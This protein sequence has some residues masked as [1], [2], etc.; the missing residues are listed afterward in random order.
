MNRRIHG[1]NSTPLVSNWMAGPN[2]PPPPP[3]LSKFWFWTYFC[4]V[5]QR[6]AEAIRPRPAAAPARSPPASVRGGRRGGAPVEREPG[7]AWFARPAAG[8]AAAGPGT[9][10]EVAT[11]R[12]RAPA[13]RVSAGF[14][15][16]RRVPARV[17][18]RIGR[19]GRP[20]RERACAI[21]SMSDSSALGGGSFGAACRAW[22]ARTRTGRSHARAAAPAAPRSRAAWPA[23][24]A[25]RAAASTG[26]RGS[27]G[28]RR[29]VPSTRKCANTEII[30]P[31][32]REMAR[33]MVGVSGRASS[34]SMYIRPLTIIP[35]AR[36]GCRGCAAR[37]PR[38][39]TLDRPM[40]PSPAT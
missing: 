27:S 10:A 30:T 13:G 6:L 35:G 16:L 5:L 3:G 28:R 17:R 8:S 19:V 33:S 38:R 15:A 11:S 4:E 32:R 20:L 36:G 14:D 26:R 9:V 7:V 23:G 18:Q 29:S 37:E 24:P 25:P 1:P 39:S 40:S 34:K 21:R 2:W 22:A 12:A 31:S